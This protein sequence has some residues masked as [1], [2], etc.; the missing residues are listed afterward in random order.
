MA[1][2]TY[3]NKSENPNL[4]ESDPRRNFTA[5][6][7]NEIKAAVNSKQDAEV[8]KGL[9]TNDYNNTDKNKVT[10]LP[11]DTI[12]ELSNKV[13]V[14]VGKGLSQANF[15]NA[16]KTKLAS[17]SITYVGTFV[18]LS[19]LQNAYP[20][21]QPGWEAIID[22]GSG[23]GPQKA[24]WDSSDNQ[25]VIQTT[26]GGGGGASSFS[27]LAGSPNDNAALAAA[28]AAKANVSHSHSI[29]DVT[30]LQ[31]E[32]NGKAPYRMTIVS[33]DANYT[34]TNL[35]ELY[36]ER[37]ITSSAN[38]TVTLPSAT[39]LAGLQVGDWFDVSQAGTGQVSFVAGAGATVNAADNATKIRARH[40]VVRFIYVEANTWRA[41]GDIT[42]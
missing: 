39:S 5:D 13:N 41:I 1:N 25:W 23:Q 22:A 3:L 16:E 32:L 27:E 17:L 34:L 9:S 33:I 26:G 6:D 30:G 19:A 20:N 10:N 29:S 31:S 11:S 38:R 36:S 21:G 7:A 42:P 40:A 28:L 12:L 4:P 14:E 2:I 15:T 18:S 35:N 8:G 24:F 37:R